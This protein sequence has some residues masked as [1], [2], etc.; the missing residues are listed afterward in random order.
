[1][2]ASDYIDSVYEDAVFAFNSASNFANTIASLDYRPEIHGLSLVSDIAI[3]P[4]YNVTYAVDS[5]PL[6]N[7]PSVTSSAVP[8]FT[9]STELTAFA[10]LIIPDFTAVIPD[11]SFPTGVT[12]S[13]PDAPT[14]RPTLDAIEVP[15][16]PVYSLPSL[17]TLSN[18]VV[19]DDVNVVIPTFDFTFNIPRPSAPTNTFTYNE[20]Q[21]TSTLLTAALELLENDIENGGYGLRAEDELNIWNRA[22]DRI[23]KA[24]ELEIDEAE[25]SIATRGF[26]MPLGANN[27]LIARSSQNKIA[28]LSQVNNEIA[29]KRADMFV[30]ARQFAVTTGLNAQQFMINLHNSMQERLLNANRYLAQ[31]GLD[32]FDASIKDFQNGL[33]QYKTEASIYESKLRAAL[34]NLD[35]YRSK[36]EAARLK[37]QIN[38]DAIELYNAQ[39]RGVEAV[40]NIYNAQLQG[41]KVKSELQEL[42]FRVYGEDIKAYVAQLEADSQKVQNYRALVDTETAKLEV[43][44]AQAKSYNTVL[45]GVKTKADI[46]KT[47]IDTEISEVNLK[48]QAYKADMDKWQ[49]EYEVAFNNAKLLLEK[50]G[51]DVDAWV[52]A[53]GFKL[54]EQELRLRAH[55]TNINNLVKTQSFN[56]EKYKANIDTFL[57]TFDGISRNQNNAGEAYSRLASSS[58][59]ALNT[60]AAIIE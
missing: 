45:D 40:I 36:L 50:Q 33:E 29:I 9:A 37:G 57:K 16:A 59:S 6:V 11:I 51:V 19:P 30:Q 7:T 2:A 14:T 5:Q 60:I 21:Y 35:I 26:T 39:F 41:V 53:Q 49:S 27:A 43:F 56:V 32:Y 55:D 44:N 23:T 8:S 42:K 52:R 17:P 46:Q 47:R 28:Q 38:Q 12:L 25:S 34:S 54:N 4:N 48:L 20:T 18:V 3:Q 10:D 1:M 13:N 58:Y 15:N 22:K 31:F 24:S